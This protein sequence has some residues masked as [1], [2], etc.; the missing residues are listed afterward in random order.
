MVRGAPLPQAAL[1]N[2]SV[3]AFDESPRWKV[4]ELRAL[5][6]E[7]LERFEGERPTASDAWLAPRLHSTVRL[8][9][10]EAADS[11]LWNFIALRVGPDYVRWRW[12]KKSQGG[13]TVVGQAARFSGRWDIQAFSRLW[14]A[15]E[16]FRDGD[17]YAP[18]VV[19]CGNQDVLNTALRLDMNHHRP[20]AQALVR[21]LETEVVRTGRDVNGLVKAAGAAGS[22]LVYEALAADEP[23]DHEAVRAWIDAVESDLL[24]SPGG[25]PR[26]PADGKAPNHSVEK[27]T[28]W[29]ANL[30]ATAPV[31][32]REL[33]E[34]DEEEVEI[35]T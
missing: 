24:W 33:G 22:T 15:A 2:G 3:D 12:G 21:L 7:V 34:S 9:R 17:E 10:A 27:L 31:R 13:R 5:L 19:A 18:V 29:F 14:W 26:G 25:L 8:F 28:E 35:R 32:G 16:L 6:D 4:E 20:S 11:A 30:F 23:R 1:I